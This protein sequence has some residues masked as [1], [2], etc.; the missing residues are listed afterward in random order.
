MQKAAMQKHRRNIGKRAATFR[1]QHKARRR[2]IFHKEG[3]VV[4]SNR[5]YFVIENETI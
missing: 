5:K 2:C 3:P 1:A 4:V